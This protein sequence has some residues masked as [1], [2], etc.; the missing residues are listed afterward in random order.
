MTRE[1]IKLKAEDIKKLEDLEDDIVWMGDEINRAERAGMDIEEI[2][3]KYNKMV[4]L[5][6][7]M[8]REYS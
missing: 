2:K 1:R 5:R 8:L 4:N 7:G 6:E 3:G